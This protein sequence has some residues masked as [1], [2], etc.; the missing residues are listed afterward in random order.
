MYKMETTSNKDTNK[1]TKFFWDMEKVLLF[2]DIC[3]EHKEKR[4]RGQPFNWS[5]IEAE[6]KKRSTLDWGKQALKNKFDGMKR[7]WRLWRQLKDSDTG[8]GWNY[9]LG[10][11]D[12]SNEWWE[13]KIQVRHLFI[14]IL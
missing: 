8:L 2:I 3:I 6:F 13:R 14:L 4:G 5:L 12:C 10:T 11:L 7:D 1:V 9:R